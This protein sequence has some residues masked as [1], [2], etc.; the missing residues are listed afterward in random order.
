MKAAHFEFSEHELLL[1][2]G[3]TTENGE[4]L[5][6]GQVTYHTA[7]ALNKER[8]NVV[9]ICHALT[10][11]SDPGEWWADLFR[12]IAGYQLLNIF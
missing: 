6:F 12:E 7:G 4:E 11:N 8:D 5:D 2:D 10:A 3:F 9:W 1:D